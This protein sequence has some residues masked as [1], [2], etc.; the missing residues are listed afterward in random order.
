MG[1]AVM[2]SNFS[3]VVIRKFRPSLKTIRSL[4]FSRPRWLYAAK[5]RATSI[6]RGSAPASVSC[7]TPGWTEVAPRVMPLPSP[8]TRTFLGSRARSIGRWP[9]VSWHCRACG[10]VDAPPRRPRHTTRPPEAREHDQAGAD[11]EQA[12]H[13]QG[14]LDAEEVDQ[15]EAADAGP[16]DGTDGVGG[17]DLPD[18]AADRVPVSSETFPREREGD[19]HEERWD[20]HVEE[21]EGE[22]G[23]HAD[24]EGAHPPLDEEPLEP[25]RVRRDIP[26][27]HRHQERGDPDHDLHEAEPN[28]RP[29][30][31]R[32]PAP[33]ERHQQ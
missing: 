3:G 29:R 21:G 27:E 13:L 14:P 31:L 19:S 23:P 11:V 33:H 8:T 32:A 17:E 7:S 25:D 2:T 30:R 16:E 20:D 24:P 26:E 6:T 28:D 4:G 1:S 12:Q 18:R 15:H 22:V 10:C 9:R 5:V